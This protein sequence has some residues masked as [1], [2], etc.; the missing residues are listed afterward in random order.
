[1]RISIETINKI[2]ELNSLGKKQIDIAKELNIHQ[3]MVSYWIQGREKAIKRNVE[4][5]RK[6]SKEEKKLMQVSQ[7]EYQRNYHRERYWR[8]EIFRNKAK[9]FARNYKKGNKNA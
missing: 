6:K 9:E 1:M 5:Y 2:K 4:N 7:R 8:D 3:S